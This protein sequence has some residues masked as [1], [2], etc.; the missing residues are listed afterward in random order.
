VAPKGPAMADLDPVRASVVV[1]GAV[2]DAFTRFT[3]DI[4]QWWPMG[5]TFAGDRLTDIAIRPEPG[6]WLER[7]LDGRET[8]WGAVTEWSPPNSF[9]AEF[10]IS[11]ART[12]EPPGRRSRVRFRFTPED[13][14]A[15]V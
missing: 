1:P 3:R 4:G 8:T 7:D 15:R 14:G 5:Y 9:V 2:A 10:A 13:G 6:E 12:V 11:A